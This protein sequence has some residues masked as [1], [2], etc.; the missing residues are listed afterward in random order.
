MKGGDVTGG[1]YTN[2]V[3][4]YVVHMTGIGTREI[5][6]DIYRSVPWR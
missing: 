5:H 2:H 4:K 1:E 3:I 6:T